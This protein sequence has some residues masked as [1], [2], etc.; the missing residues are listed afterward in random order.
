MTRKKKIVEEL[1]LIIEI[2]NLTY[3]DI[4]EEIDIPYSTLTSIMTRNA[5]PQKRN[6]EKI[7]AYIDKHLAQS[8]L[9][10]KYLPIKIWIRT[11]SYC[12]NLDEAVEEAAQEIGISG[13][14]L[15]AIINGEIEPAKLALR[16]VE[17]W[18]GYTVKHLNEFKEECR[19]AE[20]KNNVK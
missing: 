5:H 13:E 12:E 3:D 11:G 20:E 4:A 16:A 1:E 19:I 2:N 14:Y 18:M 8:K 7:Q 6:K 9:K 15:Q 10:L 17:N